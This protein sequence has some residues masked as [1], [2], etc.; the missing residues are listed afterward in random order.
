MSPPLHRS[1][2]VFPTRFWN[3]AAEVHE[4]PGAI[5]LI[6]RRRVRRRQPQ[7]NWR[8]PL[9]LAVSGLLLGALLFLFTGF[10]FA[11]TPLVVAT[12]RGELLEQA[13]DFPFVGPLDG[14]LP[15]TSRITAR[16]G[17]VLAEIRDIRFGDRVSVPLKE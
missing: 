4:F 2:S 8:W 10:S 6:R 17:T 5:R 16:D 7:D 15:Q 12:A 9:A 13:V 3:N 11:A 1:I 14:E